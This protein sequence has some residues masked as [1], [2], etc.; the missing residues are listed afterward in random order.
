MTGAAPDNKLNVSATE[1]A[2]VYIANTMYHGQRQL[3]VANFEALS[4]SRALELLD[5]LDPDQAVGLLA[6]IQP[7]AAASVVTLMR[8]DQAVLVVTRMNPNWAAPIFDHLVPD[9]A[10]VLRDAVRANA[11]FTSASAV[12]RRL[13]GRFTAEVEPVGPSKRG[14]IGFSR[15]FQNGTMYWNERI[16]LGMVSAGIQQ[17]YEQ[18]GE[19]K[20]RLGFPIGTETEAAVSSFGTSGTFQRFESTWDYDEKTLPGARCGATVYRSAEYGPRVTWGGIG[21]HYERSG[22]TWGP[23]GYP[24]SEEIEVTRLGRVGYVQIFEGGPVFWSETTGAA[25]F[26]PRFETGTDRFPI[27][28]EQPVAKSR[29]GT[30]GFGQR[31]DAPW[32]YPEGVL[33][34]WPDDRPAGAVLYASDS[35]CAYLTNGVIGVCFERHGG[36][37][38]MFGFPRSNEIDLPGEPRQPVRRV[39]MF[40]GG[41]IFWSEERDTFQIVT[42]PIADLLD[43]DEPLATRLGMAVTARQPIDDGPV[44]IQFFENGVITEQMRVATAWLRHGSAKDER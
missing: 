20:G 4:P 37:G 6:G 28:D 42:G 1:R 18:M 43:A 16:G 19:A 41:R 33:A 25:R 11:A 32:T 44:W 29:F 12:W 10:A 35:D 34:G 38:G 26:T 17:Y 3:T 22:G 31:V 8:R 39:Q 15:S 14:T 13:L 7:A 30:D 23:L 2:R 5:Y 24:M 9:N 40:E 21:E 36:T 27:G